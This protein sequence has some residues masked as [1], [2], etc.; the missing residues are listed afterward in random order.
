MAKNFSIGKILS[1][2]LVAMSLAMPAVAQTAVSAPS[3]K[4][5][6]QARLKS[7]GYES[8]E[9][10]TSVFGIDECHRL[11]P[12]FGN[13]FGNNPAAPYLIVGTPYWS[14]EYIDPFYG[15]V[16]TLD[17]TNF[18][19]HRV[20]ADEAIVILG[21]TGPEAAYSGI[22]SYL[23]SRRGEPGRGLTALLSYLKPDVLQPIFM[24]APNKSRFMSFASLGDS[25]NNAVIA[26][27]VGATSGF[28]QDIAVIST[29]NRDLAE[30]LRQNLISLNFP[31]SRIFIEKL[32][33][34][35]SLGYGEGADDLMT[36][37]R[38]S[39]PKDAVA[40]NKWRY[41]SPFKV[42][43]V[44]KQVEETAVR[45][46][47]APV[48]TA[49]EG[50]REWSYRRPLDQLTTLVRQT[51]NVPGDAV[52][53]TL[54]PS[55][56]IALSGPDCIKNQMN[57]L[58]DSQDTDSYRLSS[59]VVVG[60]RDVLIVTGVNHTETGNAT[61]VSLA[62]NNS[63]VLLGVE[64]VSQTGAAAGFISGS[65]KNSTE[66][67]I[68]LSPV[69]PSVELLRDKSK[70]YV[71]L[72]ARDCTGLPQCTELS[73]DTLPLDAPALIIQRAYIRPGDVVGADPVQLVSPQMIVW[74]R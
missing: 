62:V 16:V 13:C 42:L 55:N 63:S 65:L 66:A 21:R 28:D 40:G 7:Q 1:L 15:D 5:P 47:G 74:R 32:P 31:A 44:R 57:C 43:R 58:G 18:G 46:F 12:A 54:I 50:T 6:L 29:A 33:N 48:L 52:Q 71:Q 53:S 49:K 69:T 36:L 59:S 25:I 72:F 34:L 30:A 26:K 10:T 14:D 38:Y 70:L 19:P 17:G 23:F 67:I 73:V 3:L 27:S 4:S 45:R 64:S 35:L 11:I 68:K 9:G 41:S 22:Q 20:R 56:L 8:L 61:Y 37:I 39:L 51:L 2:C 24:E 60:Q